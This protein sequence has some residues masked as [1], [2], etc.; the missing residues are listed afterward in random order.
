MNSVRLGCATVDV[1]H[2]VSAEDKRQNAG[3]EKKK[4]VPK[5]S[6]PAKATISVIKTKPVPFGMEYSCWFNEDLTPLD[7]KN[8]INVFVD[9]YFDPALQQVSNI[10][11]FFYYENEVSHSAY[12]GQNGKMHNVIGS[13][14]KGMHNFEFTRVIPSAAGGKDFVA[15]SGPEDALNAEIGDL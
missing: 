4:P 6:S 12:K 13:N 14:L 1:V 15:S 3:V 8:G 7:K 9:F 2:S 10:N 11:T 5:K